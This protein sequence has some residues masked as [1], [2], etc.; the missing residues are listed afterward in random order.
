MAAWKTQ[1]TILTDLQNQIKGRNFLA[2]QALAS[3]LIGTNDS[4]RIQLG[5]LGLGNQ[6]SSRSCAA[7][8]CRPSD[9]L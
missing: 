5:I 2:A 8:S 6:L 3:S 4:D 1:Y 7:W 9:D